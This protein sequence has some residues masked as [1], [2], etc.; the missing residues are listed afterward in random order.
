[1][2][3]RREFYLALLLVAAIAAMLGAG[4]SRV[5]RGGGFLRAAEAEMLAAKPFSFAA[6]ARRATPSVVNVFTTHHVRVAPFGP[7]LG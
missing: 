3:S 1:M 5:P 7:P 4:F 6:V 2:V